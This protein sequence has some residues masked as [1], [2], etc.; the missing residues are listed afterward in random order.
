MSLTFYRDAM[1]F[2][3]KASVNISMKLSI[4]MLVKFREILHHYA[5]NRPKQVAWLTRKPAFAWN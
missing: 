1:K 2:S 5:C 3:M 4:F